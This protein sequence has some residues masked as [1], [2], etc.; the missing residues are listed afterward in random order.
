MEADSCGTAAVLSPVLG[1]NAAP[2]SA[3]QMLELVRLQTALL[4]RRRVREL[5]ERDRRRRQYRRRRR[6]F[7]LSSLAAILSLIASTSR[8]VWVR[9]RG[10]GLSFWAAAESFDDAEWKAQFRVSRATFDFLLEQIG[11]TIKRRRT[12]YRLP[13]EPR[14]R[15]AIALWWFSRSGEYRSIALMFGVGIAT[16]CMIVRQVTAAIVE[17]LYRRYVSLPSGR[18][19]DDTLRA[20]RGRCYP[21]CAGAIGDTHIPIAP[22]RHN[23]EHY[24]NKRGWYSVILQAVV[25]HDIWWVQILVLVLGLVQVQVL[26]LT[27]VWSRS[28]SCLSVSS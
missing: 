28:R 11:A 3:E 16:V 1:P 4:S 27:M 25:D 20:F 19:L 7:L 21:Q 26:V 5:L 12:N 9:S 17:R 13:I 6:A 8:P 10:P 2:V 23:P 22:P 15:L 18:R 24:M 14:R